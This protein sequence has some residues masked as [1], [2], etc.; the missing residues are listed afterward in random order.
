MRTA[1]VAAQLALSLVLLTTAGLL[2]ISLERLLDVNPGFVAS[3]T[4][5]LSLKLPPTLRADARLAKAKQLQELIRTVPGVDSVSFASRIP[6]MGQNLS[7]WLWI[8]GRPASAA[9]QVPEVEYR[10]VSENYFSTLGIPLKAG[11]LFDSSDESHAT[12]VVVVNEAVASRYFPGENPIGKRVR[13]SDPKRGPW[14]TIVGVV[15]NLRHFGLDLAPRPEIY[16]PYAVS[17]LTAP[18]ALVR[19]RDPHAIIPQVAAAIRAHDPLIPVFN[20]V[21][22]QDLVDR[23]T[24]R[25]R[26]PA[27]LAIAFAML[28]VAIAAVGLAGVAMNSVRQRRREF[29]VRLALGATASEVITLVMKDNLRTLIVGTMI[30]LPVAVIVSLLLRTLL[31]ST[32]PSDPAAWVGAPVVLGVISAIACWLPA[33]RAARIDPAEILRSE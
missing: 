26:L 22:M 30:G 4:A 2:A 17:P 14:V 12:D 11:R 31:Y 10:V 29:G 25:R 15:G 9:A 21:P 20:S 27:M 6:M 32:S 24:L 7:S 13:F 3:E 23:S 8:E 16:R 19:S 33:R 5:S 28:A 18:I 1:L